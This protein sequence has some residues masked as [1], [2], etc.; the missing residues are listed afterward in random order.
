MTTNIHEGFQPGD[1]VRQDVKFRTGRVVKRTGPVPFVYAVELADG[2]TVFAYEGELREA[3][4]KES[5][6]YERARTKWRERRA[7]IEGAGSP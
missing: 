2:M 7:L 1:I 3:T 5:E 4:R 6:D